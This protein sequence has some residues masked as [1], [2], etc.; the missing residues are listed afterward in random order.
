MQ[1]RRVGI[2][3]SL[4]VSLRYKF[5]PPSRKGVRSDDASLIETL[6]TVAG[7]W[8][9]GFFSTLL[10]QYQAIKPKCFAEIRQSQTRAC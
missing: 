5:F 8:S 7:G 9:K 3:G 4:R 2:A 1:T 6:D 10:R